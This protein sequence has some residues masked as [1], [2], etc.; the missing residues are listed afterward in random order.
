MNHQ[1]AFTI[2]QVDYQHHSNE[3]LKTTIKVLTERVS[4]LEKNQ[5]ELVTQVE[6]GNR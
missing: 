1:G 3:E 4:W 5:E 2:S 6:D